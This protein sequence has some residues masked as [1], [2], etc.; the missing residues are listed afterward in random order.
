MENK[1]ISIIMD[2]NFTLYNNEVYSPHMHYDAFGKKFADYFN[3]VTIVARAFE[4]G[5]RVGNL[6]T[7]RNVVFKNIG[8][9]RG[10]VKLLLSIPT[11]VLELK[12]VINKSDIILIRF[13]GNVAIIS[14]IL[15]L[16][17]N[18]AFHVE[19]V[20]EPRDYFT[21]KASD[22]FLRKLAQYIHVKTTM[23]A[24]C[25]ALSVRYVTKKY[26]Q[27]RYPAKNVEFGFSDVFLPSDIP[28]KK[29]ELY[30]KTQFIV[31]NVGMMHNNSKGHLDIINAVSMLVKVI[32]NFKMIFIGGGVNERIFKDKVSE[33]QL[34]QYFEFCGVVAP[35]SEVWKVLIKAD[36]FLLA[37]YQEGMPRSL[38]E[39][40]T[41][42][43]P[44]IATS[45]GGIP[46]VLPAQF[47]YEPGNI[48]DLCDKIILIA[49]ND[50]VYK[51]GLDNSLKL[52]QDFSSENLNLQYKK[53]FDSLCG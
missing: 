45:V 13:P 15:C 10:L 34:D 48:K 26:L 44:C 37:S 25:K 28:K 2:G 27:N 12:R 51:L 29:Y 7:G 42:G 4:K 46:E 31:C 32:P 47:L 3:K 30:N 5:Q 52:S 17:F 33:L 38:L 6:V 50:S 18:K 22:H 41:A 11:K 9:N 49:M 36:L 20:A 35:S 16:I 40:A 39:A 19:I 8:N 24:A 23:Y 53:Y 21:K 14:M 43:L 1:H